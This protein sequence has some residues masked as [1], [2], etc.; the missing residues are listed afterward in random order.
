MCM[1]LGDK[2]FELEET[3][4]CS[5]MANLNESREVVSVTNLHRQMVPFSAHK[6]SY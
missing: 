6:M 5:L 1:V 2:K 4:L 3:A